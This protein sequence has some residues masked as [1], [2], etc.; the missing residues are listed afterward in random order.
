MRGEQGDWRDGRGMIAQQDAVHAFDCRGALGAMLFVDPESRE[1]AWLRTVL[2]TDITIVPDARLTSSIAALRTFVDQP[3]ESLEVG[4][5]IRHCVS[6][7]CSST[8]V[9]LP[10]SRYMLWRK[11]TRAMVAIAPSV[12]MRG[13]FAAIPSPFGVDSQPE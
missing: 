5:L 10:F 9:G 1:G 4:A 11:L 6:P 12:L 7:I 8:R 3:F 2:A 13:D